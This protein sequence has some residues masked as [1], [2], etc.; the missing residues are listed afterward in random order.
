MDRAAVGALVAGVILAVAGVAVVAL[1]RLGQRG[2]LPLQAW[3][4]IRT[5]STMRSDES[6]MAAHRAGGPLIEFAG[7]SAVALGGVA[8]LL[9][10]ADERWTTA[11][12][13]APVGIFLVLLV[14]GGIRGDQAARRVNS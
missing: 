12:T 6:W 8:A 10:A 9:S 13:L 4:G 5:R 3:A 2:R 11:I 14:A 7:W 1:G